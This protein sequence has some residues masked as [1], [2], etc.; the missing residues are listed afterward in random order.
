MEQFFKFFTGEPNSNTLFCVQFPTTL[1]F[2]YEISL[3][4]TH[5]LARSATLSLRSQ[6]YERPSTKL[7]SRQESRFKACG[8][9]GSSVSAKNMKSLSGEA[10]THLI[11]VVLD[12]SESSH[13]E[14][15]SVEA[16]KISQS[17][18]RTGIGTVRHPADEARNV[19]LMRDTLQC[20][21]GR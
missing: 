16:L 20:C 10:D 7:W 17:V 5:I 9:S 19:L 4:C 14:E 15:S 11:A 18:L 3:L 8:L 21:V 1:Q 2:G 12:C 6:V 13:S